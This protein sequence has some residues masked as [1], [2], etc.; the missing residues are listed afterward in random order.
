IPK[1]IVPELP[2]TFSAYGMLFADLRHDYVRTYIRP[3]DA[4][5][6]GEANAGFDD[7]AEEATTTLVREGVGAGGIRI[8]RS[9]DLRYRGQEYT[10]SVPV[11]DGAMTPETLTALRK[12]FDEMHE[13]KYR[14]SAP[15]E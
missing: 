8:Q 6:L 4:L 13:A 15:H 9:V 14:H 12:A 2:G 11:P 3:L 5:D 10:L 1:V 7:M